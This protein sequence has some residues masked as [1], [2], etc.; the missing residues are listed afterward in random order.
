MSAAITSM[1]FASL[2]KPAEPNT[3]MKFVKQLTV[4]STFVTRGTQE[5]ANSL[6][7]LV[8]ANLVTTVDT[9]MWKEF[10]MKELKQK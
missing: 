7:N 5:V 4:K 10:K 3:M 9:N 8:D 6:V 2:A 1:A